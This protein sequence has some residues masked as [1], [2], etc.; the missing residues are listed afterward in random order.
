MTIES[1][2]FVKG[3]QKCAVKSSKESAWGNRATDCC[4]GHDCNGHNCCGKHGCGHD[5]KCRGDEE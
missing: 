2:S 5:C 4:S 1:K 3:C